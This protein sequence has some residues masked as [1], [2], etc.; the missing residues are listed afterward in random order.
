MQSNE[1]FEKLSKLDTEQ[2]NPRTRE[3]D[4]CSTEEILKLIN[5]EDRIVPIAVEKEIKFISQGVD[6]IVEAFK[7]GGRLFYVGAGTSGRLG[8]LDAAECP[9]TFGT[10]PE[11]VQGIIAG[12]REAVF[13]AQEGAEDILENG[14]KEIVSRNVKPPD[15]VCGIAASGRTPFVIGAVNEAKSRGCKTL[16]ICTI[17]REQA[18]EMGFEA[19]VMICPNVGP[20]VIAGSTRMKSGT[21]QKLVLNMLTTATMIRL[22]KTYGNI[23]VDLQLTNEKLKYRAIRIIMMITKADYQTAQEYLEKADGNVKTAIVMILKKIDKVEALNELRKS[24][25]FVRKAIT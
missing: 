22:G 6:L 14:V 5:D 9:P 17:S 20:E 4:I 11:M 1:L 10:E 15:I 18:K 24:Q 3:I 2:I 23:M 25:G 8:I 12:G 21:A 13:V 7:Q 19:D 16:F